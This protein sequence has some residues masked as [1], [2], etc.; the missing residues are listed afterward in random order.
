MWSPLSVEK[1]TAWPQNRFWPSN[2]TVAFSLSFL[3]DASI[4][5][6]FRR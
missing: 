6:V 2:T 3:M 5:N 1:S 4:M